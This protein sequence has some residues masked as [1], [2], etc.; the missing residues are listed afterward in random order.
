MPEQDKRR[1][2][3]ATLRQDIR[4]L[5]NTLGQAIRRHEGDAVFTTVEQLR[6]ACIHLR[7]C[8][9]RLSQYKEHQQYERQLAQQQIT[10]LSQ[11]ILQIV[12]GCDLDMATDVIRAFT[13]YFHL[14]NTAEQYHRIRRRRAHDIEEQHK[15]LRDSLA[16][17]IAFLKQNKLETATVQQILNQLSIDIVFTAHPTEATRRSLI[18]KSRR[19]AELLEAHDTEHLMTPRERLRWQRDLEGTIDLLWR[20]DAVRRVRPEPIDEIKMG[21]YYLDEILYDALADLYSEFEDLL[22]KVYPEVTVPPFLH[23]SS[24]IGG[25]QDG[26]PFVSSETLLTALRL[27]RDY[28]IQHYRIA[29]RALAEEYSQSSHHAHISSKLQQSLEY[30]AAC[31]PHYA[32]E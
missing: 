5:G 1:E 25:D 21:I 6:N 3:D 18:T 31:F 16:A 12:N 20:T 14:V 4:T 32:Q 26:N 30:D 15:P 13:V 11:E 7:D 24:W 10:A 8:T 9:Q 2:K 23:L 22:H 29:V 17:L 19:I 27:Q 28:I